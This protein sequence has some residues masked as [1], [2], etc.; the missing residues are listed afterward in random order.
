[1]NNTFNEISTQELFN[2][3]NINNIKIIDVRS[4]N[5]YNGWQLKNEVRGGHIFGAKSLPMKWSN[6][7]D[8]IEIVRSKHITPEN[9]IIIYSY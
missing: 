2:S 7:I 8:W 5:A 4:V 1:M 3:L 6:Y 9:S